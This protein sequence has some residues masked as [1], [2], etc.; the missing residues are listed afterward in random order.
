LYGFAD[1]L[2]EHGDGLLAN[3]SQIIQVIITA[4]KYGLDLAFIKDLAEWC[5]LTV[6]RMEDAVMVLSALKMCTVGSEIHPSLTTAVDRIISTEMTILVELPEWFEWAQSV[7]V[8]HVKIFREAAVMKLLKRSGSI[9]ICMECEDIDSDWTE[10]ECS[11]GSDHR[12]QQYE[13]V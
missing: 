10:N 2:T 12:W 9:E 5:E 7:P 3:A 13:K 6:A 11:G 1:H 4:D 8:V